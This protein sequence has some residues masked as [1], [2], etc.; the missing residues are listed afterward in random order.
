MPNSMMWFRR[1]LRLADNH[2]LVA[3]VDAARAGNVAVLAVFVLDDALWEPSGPNRRWFLARCLAE[4]D[5]ALGGGLVTRHG[6]PSEV[7]PALAA[8]YDC[9]TVLRAQDVC[10]YGRRR[11][12]AVA[13]A[14]EGAGRQLVEADS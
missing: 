10:V 12:E 7:V 2:T 1:D 13:A 6:V 14:L 11:D 5:E 4:L 8:E 9:A 3:A